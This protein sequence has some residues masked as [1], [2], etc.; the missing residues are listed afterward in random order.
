[1]EDSR[2]K[3]D[4]LLRRLHAARR[5]ASDAPLIQ[6]ALRPG[7]I[8]R[9]SW[10]VAF[11]DAGDLG[12][13]FDHDLVRADE[14]SE[15]VVARPMPADAPFDR[16]AAFAQTAGAAHD[17]V[18]VRH[19]ERDMVERRRRTARERQDMVLIV[20]AEERHRPRLVDDTESEMVD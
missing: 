4:A 1:M 20:A 12:G 2:R 3:G 10:L 14:I 19:L 16:K 18:D 11:A 5:T 9:A 15:H 17:A 6:P 13:I 8:F 7:P